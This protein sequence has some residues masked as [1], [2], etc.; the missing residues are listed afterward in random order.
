M[1]RSR[2]FR[3][4]VD[5]WLQVVLWA[6]VLIS[7]L[8]MVL[9]S[10]LETQP[11][12]VGWLALLS[13]PLSL[14]A[15]NLW[16]LRGTDY[17]FDQSELRIRSGPLRVR[18]PLAAITA[19]TPSRTWLSGP[20]LSLDRLVIHYGASRQVIVSPEDQAGFLREIEAARSLA[21]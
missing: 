1:S 2:T 21:R 3:S 5:T 16:L 18:V 10:G 7:A 12:V 14:A 15:L 20:A 4:K 11:G 8:P 9:L 6:S 13:I 17:T 19:V